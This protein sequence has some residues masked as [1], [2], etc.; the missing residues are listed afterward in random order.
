MSYDWPKCHHP[1]MKFR[2]TNRPDELGKPAMGDAYRS[3]WVCGR[4][5]CIREAMGWVVTGTGQNAIIY[6]ENR[7]RVELV[8][9]L[10]RTS[11]A[12]RS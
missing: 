2:V 12:S 4:P 6:D 3:T 11:Q 5:K 1:E 7:E 8:D 10:V 9:L